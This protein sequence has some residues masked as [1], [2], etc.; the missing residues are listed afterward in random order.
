MGAI[1]T[2]NFDAIAASAP[3]DRQASAIR[4]GSGDLYDEQIKSMPLVPRWVGPPVMKDPKSLRDMGLVHYRELV[5][6]RFG[7]LVVMGIWADTNPKKNSVW[8]CRCDCGYYEGR[9]YKN[10]TN[11]TLEHACS[12]CLQTARL[13]R[14]GTSKSTFD[15]RRA[16]GVRLD[17]IA[18]G[19]R[20]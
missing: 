20:R 15:S 2:T 5:G 9:K 10:L 4:D 17:A 13:R 14:M 7:S 11:P 6:N 3:L 12:H 19:G 1:R 18:A 8:V 16:E